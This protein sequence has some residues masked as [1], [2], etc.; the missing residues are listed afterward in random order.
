[1]ENFE[2]CNPDRDETKWTPIKAEGI[3]EA[4]DEVIQAE[5]SAIGDE[6]EAEFD[7]ILRDICK[8]V[9]RWNVR[10]EVDG[11]EIDIYKIEITEDF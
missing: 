10:I 8:V 2:Y 9:R 11:S 6:P 5:V 4:L 1:M 3:E 7:L